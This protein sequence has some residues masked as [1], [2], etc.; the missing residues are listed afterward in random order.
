M[1]LYRPTELLAFLESIGQSPKKGLSQN[2]LIDGNVIQNIIKTADVQPQDNVLE[3]G[4]GP[5]SLTEALLNAGANVVAV[6][7]D[8]KLAEALNRLQ[9]EDKRL[10]IFPADALKVPLNE[11]RAC[12]KDPLKP[13][14]LISNL[15]YHITTPLLSRF[16]SQNNWLSTVVVMVQ[17]EMAK[18]MCGKKSTP[19]YG[20]ITVF[21]NFYAH[22]SYAFKVG[23]NCFYPAPK[24]DSAIVKFDL[25]AP[26]VDVDEEVFFKMTRRAFEQRRKVLRSSLKDLYP[27]ERVLEALEKLGVPPLA[28]PEELS[29]EDFIQ[30]YHLLNKTEYI[31]Q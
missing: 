8:H 19:D 26:P 1:P 20:S 21:L 9:T 6:E 16:I 10:R 18:R 2:F 7:M 3:I 15:P 11:I 12:F 29:C 30:F 28:R 4:P 5:G 25:K 14:K 13:V 27:P 24:V 31:E 23:R 17:N 22:V